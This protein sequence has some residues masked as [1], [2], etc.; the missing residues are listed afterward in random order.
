MRTRRN[1]DVLPT[2]R[3][4]RTE[5]TT[6]LTARLQRGVEQG[7]ELAAA[8]PVAATIAGALLVAS[9]AAAATTVSQQSLTTV[10]L[11]M[12]PL[13]S[14]QSLSASSVTAQTMIAGMYPLINYVSSATTEWHAIAYAVQNNGTALREAWLRSIA[15]RVRMQRERRMA[16]G[17][18]EDRG[19]YDEYLA[20]EKHLERGESWYATEAT[21][22]LWSARGRDR[23]LTALARVGLRHTGWQVESP[24]SISGTEAGVVNMVAHM[25]IVD[26]CPIGYES[27]LGSMERALHKESLLPD[28]EKLDHTN[29]HG[30]ASWL[31]VAYWINLL[32][33]PAGIGTVLCDDRGTAAGCARWGLVTKATFAAKGIQFAGLGYFYN[34]TIFLVNFEAVR[35]VAFHNQ[36]QG[37]F[38]DTDWKV[39]DDDT[40]IKWAR[41]SAP[42]QAHLYS[43]PPQLWFPAGMVEGLVGSYHAF[44]PLAALIIALSEL[45][46]FHLVGH[47]HNIYQ[48]S[49][50]LQDVFK[51][52]EPGGGG[53]CDVRG[54]IINLDCGLL[55]WVRNKPWCVNGVCLPDTP[56]AS[57]D[58][59]NV[60]NADCAPNLHL[61]I[62]HGR[63]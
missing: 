26:Q 2:A 12:V 22:P 52:R 59:N 24:N 56:P 43:V 32:H 23:A 51:P 8:H 48:L 45:D 60:D 30:A 54:G 25:R 13:T 50:A 19:A 15:E 10:P 42:L 41:I 55:G 3:R 47:N 18:H 53:Y 4:Q 31:E 21:R 62:A 5:P 27:I 49:I 38:T 7:R 11:T 46:I 34:A 40:V 37:L 58:E 33:S 36:G 14:Q 29:V 44:R 28:R 9:V 1:Q 16:P 17:A 57:F 63:C 35:G 61:T 6:I 20:L 39:H